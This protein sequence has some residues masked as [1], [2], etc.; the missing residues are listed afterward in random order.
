MKHFL[1]AA[2][3]LAAAFLT[4]SKSVPVYTL[5]DLTGRFNPENHPD[6]VQVP[7]RFTTQATT[8][9]KEA[10]EAYKQMV[11]AAQRD[12]INLMIVSGTRN[13]ERQIEIWTEKWNSL[14]GS[15]KEK[16]LEILHY[17]S[18]PGT[19]RHHWGTDIDINTVEADY[20]ETEQ[21]MRVYEWLHE[22]AI[23]YG[24]FQP[25]IAKGDQR[26]AGYHEEKW[27]WSYFPISDQMIRAYK[28]MVSYDQIKG[29][30]G[31][32]IAPEIGV[33]EEFVNGIP[34][35]HEINGGLYSVKTSSK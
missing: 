32:E 24:F 23:K 17:S 35:L 10:F 5:A 29:F 26:Q 2:T 1:L 19:S 30:P 11:A 20:F 6:F 12:G 25:Y 18:M 7:S 8:M 21:G 9:R 22:N 3:L 34:D 4:G 15:P 13:R 28:R 33:I 27:H 14:N 16:A 31:A